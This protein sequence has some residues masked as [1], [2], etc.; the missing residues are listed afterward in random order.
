MT[1]PPADLWLAWD[2]WAALAGIALATFASEDLTCIATGLLIAPGR[3]DP[4]VGLVGCFLGIFVGDVGLWLLGR[5]AGRGLLGRDWVARRL[6]ARRL[7]RLGAWLDGHC[8]SAAVAARFLPGTRLPIYLAAGALSRCRAR[9]VVWTAV[10]GLVWTP[11]LVLSVAFLGERVTGPLQSLLGSAWLALA[12]AGAYLGFHVL[13]KLGSL[14]GRAQ[15]AAAVAR[16]WRWEFWPTWLF[17]LSL[18]P[19]IGWLALRHRSLTVWTAAN[20]GIPAGGVVGESKYAILMSLPA[21]AIIPSALIPPG[22]TGSR[23]ARLREAMAA[24]GWAYP[25]VLKPDAAQRGA[26]VRK[27]RDAVEAEKYLQKQP[28]A[29]LGQPYHPGPFEAG[30][31]YYRLP[32]E[33][34]GHI[35]SITD[36]VFPAVTGDGRSTIEELIWSHPRYRMQARTFLTRHAA[37]AGRVPAAG[38]RFALALAG[39]H[40]QGTQFCDGSHLATP[41]LG[42]AVDA[43]AQRFPGFF[44]GRFD[45]R[46]RDRD[47]LR[48]GHGLA[49][50]ELNGV[51]SESTNVYDPA[52]SLVAAYRTLYRQ[53]ALAFRIGAANRRRGHAPTPLP[54]LARAVLHYYRHQP[55]D[56][57]AD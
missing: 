17:Y 18:L 57:L 52:R 8:G 39:N 31:F 34:A 29:V 11:L 28:A 22:D 10:A 14:I 2:T 40:C 35:F 24:Q 16:L 3:V 42:R 32:G 37:E 47:N 36:K 53:W 23:L 6:P 4:W 12:A 5:L 9:F 55:T 46:Y 49:V 54:A 33:P 26:G 21:E 1:P 30:V 38:E 48:A 43:I 44:I 13:T 51:L 50:V 27:V 41:A 56:P 15:L 20:P 7:Q 25:L 45:I 19:A